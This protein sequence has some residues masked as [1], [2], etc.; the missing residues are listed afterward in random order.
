[1]HSKLPML[2]QQAQLPDSGG[3]AGSDVASSSWFDATAA[4]PRVATSVIKIG[5]LLQQ[6]QALF[7][8]VGSICTLMSM[9]VATV[10]EG[11]V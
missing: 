6:E 5:S 1:M 4:L 7:L 2:V 8:R 9:H 3:T 11:A 10:F